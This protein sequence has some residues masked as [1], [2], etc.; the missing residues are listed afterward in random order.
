MKAK[1]SAI[2]SFSA[3]GAIV[4]WFA[5]ILQLYLII[6][7]RTVSIPET[8]L[9]FFTF[10]TILSN[11]LVAISFTVL[12][13]KPAFEND[14]FFSRAGVLSA[15]TVYIAIVGAVYQLVLRPLW[16]PQ[17][18]QKVVDEL[19]HSF[20]PVYFILFWLLYVPKLTLQW[21]HIFSWLLFPLCY[22][23]IILLRG[24][25]AGYYPYPFVNVA[26]LGYGQVFLNC[27][28]VLIAFVFFSILLISAGKLS[29]KTSG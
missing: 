28:M 15:V 7:N 16:D 12:V 4:A 8:L 1:P 23:I 5:V 20:T 6:V 27:G 10:F 25:M 18:L 11:I 24:A 17:G 3:I 9:R 29:K 13:L 21:Q 2:R 22:L 19:L 26:E 14:S